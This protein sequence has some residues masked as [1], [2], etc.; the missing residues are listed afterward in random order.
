MKKFDLKLRMLFIAFFLM[1][2]SNSFSLIAGGCWPY[3]Y[4][5]GEIGGNYHYH[6]TAVDCS[7]DPINNEYFRWWINDDLIQN[8]GNTFVYEP[9]YTDDFQTIVI[10]VRYSCGMSG[11]ND[12]HTITLPPQCNLQPDFEYIV[13]GSQFQL[14]NNST[15]N[16]LY[17]NSNLNCFWDFGDGTTLTSLPES[18]VTHNYMSE[19]IF[20]IC[21]TLS[22][23]FYS[24]TATTVC[25]NVYYYHPNKLP[26]T[27]HNP[28]IELYSVE[29][30]TQNEFVMRIYMKDESPINIFIYSID[31]ILVH[32]QS[33]GM[34]YPGEQTIEISNWSN[35]P[36]GIYLIRADVGKET[37][38]QKFIRF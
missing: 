29:I 25:K 10:T 2:C 30:Q 7:G 3:I 20:S 12:T 38:T 14:T 31:G 24:C 9:V 16:N 15:V 37:Q 36:S 23:S 21:L 22:N 18:L 32:S 4:Y 19:G 6:A 13:I 8:G 35:L 27:I 33:K 1:L 26:A 5:D 11:D 28:L 34:Q 17:F